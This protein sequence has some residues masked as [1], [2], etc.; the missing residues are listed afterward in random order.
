MLRYLNLNFKH[1]FDS[2]LW[3]AFSDPVLRRGIF[4]TSR[5][6]FQELGICMGEGSVENS[7]DCKNPKFFIVYAK[8]LPSME[9]SSI[10]ESHKTY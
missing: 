4:A 9:D 10:E 8:L 3:R 6:G 2:E 5:G 7:S 1:A